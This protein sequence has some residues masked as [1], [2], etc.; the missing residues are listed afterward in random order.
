MEMHN[1]AVSRS[2]GESRPA[3]MLSADRAERQEAISRNEVSTGLPA[4]A[5]APL[6]YSPAR[7]WSAGP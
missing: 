6:E 1:P 2:K 4:L 3:A 7:R 5:P